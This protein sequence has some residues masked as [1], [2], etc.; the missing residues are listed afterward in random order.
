MNNQKPPCATWNI[1]KGA[2]IEGTKDIGVSTLFI[3]KLPLAITTKRS[4][5]STIDLA[6]MRTRSNTNRL[7]LCKELMLWAANHNGWELIHRVMSYY[8]KVAIESTPELLLS[9]PLSVR[10]KAQIYLKVLPNIPPHLNL[11]AG[12]FVCVGPSFSDEAFAIGTGKKVSP[13][14][15]LNDT[16]IQ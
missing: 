6:F 1:W 2:E 8:E 7:W 16:K 9:I 12:D 5:Y 4:E 3:R 15:Y 10:D 14:Q 13:S 11:R